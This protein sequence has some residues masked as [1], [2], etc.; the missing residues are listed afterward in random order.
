MRAELFQQR[1]RCFGVRDAHPINVQ[2]RQH[3]GRVWVRI[4]LAEQDIPHAGHGAAIRQRHRK[5]GE[6]LARQRISAFDHGQRVIEAMPPAWRALQAGD[7]FDDL[8]RAESPDLQHVQRPAVLGIGQ[9]GR[10]QGGNHI[11]EQ[12]DEL[13]RSVVE[14]PGFQRC[15]Q[16]SVGGGQPRRDP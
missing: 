7:R 15:D 4:S 8:R 11:V 5:C 10:E 1:V 13:R 14:D 6:F 16:F 3:R 12:L 2:C 9:I